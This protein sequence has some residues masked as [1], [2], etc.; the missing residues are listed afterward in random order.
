MSRPDTRLR[1]ALFINAHSRRARRL[2][3]K[4][5]DDFVKEPPGF[6]MVEIIVVKNLR[7]FDYHLEVLA[8]IQ[9]L[10]C[11]IIGSGDGTINAV[12]N[13][14]KDR[15]EVVYGFLPL[16]TSNTFMRSLGLPLLY[17]AA[18]RV[19]LKQ[20]SQPVSLGSVNG[21]FFGNIA[22]IGIP[23]LVSESTTNKIKR[24]LGP[25]AY[26][27]TGLKALM[28]Y[29]A[30]HVTIINDEINESFYTRYL[31]FANG[32]YHGNI[33]LG[34]KVSVF[35]DRLALMA[36]G[37]SQSHWHN[38]GALL[39]LLIGRHESDRHVKIIP[40][41]RVFVTTRPN[42][43]IEADGEVISQSPATVEVKK[44]A[45]RVFTPAPKKL[46]QVL[47]STEDKQVAQ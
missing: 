33:S 43:A 35:N 5:I 20:Y 28:T 42:H 25:V 4:V 6:E 1:T 22:G 18:K 37:V 7:Q 45:V 47:T 15:P 32:K 2:A 8:S 12:F 14:L 41:S 38:I 30:F 3:D 40:I 26:V 16:G 34:N 17:P 44:E 29:R 46:R 27:V 10:D 36:F 24:Y 31:L 13:A 23:T 9:D 19:I 39:K 21:I 11:V